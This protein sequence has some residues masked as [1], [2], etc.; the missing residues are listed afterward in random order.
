MR[1][2]AHPL[3]PDIPAGGILLKEII[4][5]PPDRIRKMEERLHRAA[6]EAEL[7]FCGPEKVYN[8]RMA[9]ELGAWAATEGRG[10]EFHHAVY[11]AYFGEG[12]DISNQKV[13]CDLAESVGLSPDKAMRCMG[14]RG[15][16]SFVD[17]DWQFSKQMDIM[18]IPTYLV[19]G[20]RLVGV[21][22]YKRLSRFLENNGVEKRGE[23]TEGTEASRRRDKLRH[24]GTK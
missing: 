15:F 20:N 22:S 17:A 21:Q 1:W 19:N 16:E 3:N 5:T 4:K 13:L 10:D 23:R 24:R 2:R 14:T 11:A 6:A 7:S 9:Q 12:K 18:V 8:T